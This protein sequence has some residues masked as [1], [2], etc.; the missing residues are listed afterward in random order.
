M[1]EIHVEIDTETGEMKMN[2]QGFVGNTCEDVLN[3]IVKEMK[4]ETLKKEAKP[5]KYQK[6][7]VA[8]RPVQTIVKK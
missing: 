1:K 7:T 3:Q 4:A 5:E 8:G 6:V 2:T